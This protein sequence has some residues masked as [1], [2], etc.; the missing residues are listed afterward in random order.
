LARFGL[1][2]LV[3]DIVW[4]SEL[5]DKKKW[6]F[7]RKGTIKN[8]VKEDGLV[9]GSA[10]LGMLR[11]QDAVMKMITGIMDWCHFSDLP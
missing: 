2:S 3:R 11:N 4:T 7:L 9:E 5:G 6:G 10:N 1:A 8:G